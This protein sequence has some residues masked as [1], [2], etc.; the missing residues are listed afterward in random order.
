MTAQTFVVTVPHAS[1]QL[2]LGRCACPDG[3]SLT[4][5]GSVLADAAGTLTAQCDGGFTAQTN[6]AMSW[7]SQAG[8]QVHTAAGMELFAGGG[9]A[10]GACGGAAP[11][12]SPGSSTPGATTERFV[13]GALAAASLARNVLDSIGAGAAAVTAQ[14]LDGAKNAGELSGAAG[15]PGKDAAPYAET[16][17]G[18]VSVVASL[19]SGDI[20]GAMGGAASVVS[21]VAG[22]A[23][24]SDLTERA[25][26]NIAMV[27]GTMIT[28]SAGLG[29]EYK[30]LN[31]FGVTAGALTSFTT[32]V[33]GA[34]CLLKFEVKACVAVKAKT[35][36]VKFEA[37]KSATMDAKAKLTIISPT[38]DYVSKLKVT[39]TLTVKGATAL[40]KTLEVAKKKPTTL[41]GTLTVDKNVVLQINMLVDK[42]VEAKAKATVAKKSTGKKRAT[43]RG[44]TVVG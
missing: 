27:A 31:K 40:E 13:N 19:A 5:V 18:A 11:A 10:P 44:K 25:A 43:V 28:G 36:L 2:G 37:S 33:W 4:T 30:T 15:G 8:T 14:V 1:S 38:I 9:V 20:A 21:G 32:T 41:N 12:G 17:S 39:K 29:F 34:F 3:A 26:E 22:I 24:G 35:K 7:L 42:N 6:A 16:A 23:G